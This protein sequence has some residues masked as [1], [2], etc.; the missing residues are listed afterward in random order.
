MLGEADT[1][2]FIPPTG[3]AV[4]TREGYLEV[5]V[6]KIRSN[7]FQPRRKMDPE[8]I[9]ELASSITA[10]GLIQPLV[11]NDSGEGNFEL[12]SGERRLRAVKKLGWDRV[13]AIVRQVGESELLEITLVENLQR[14]DLNSIE[15]AMGYKRLSEEFHLTQ[16]RIAE[17]IG[18]DRATIAN[19]MRLLRLP[20]VI[21][22]EVASG[23]L[24]AGHARQL[25]ALDDETEQMELARRVIDREISVRRLEEI[26]RERK[27]S[28]EVRQVPGSGE[29]EKDEPSAQI[30]ALE[31]RLSRHLGTQVRI[32]NGHKGKGKIEVN[33][34]SFEE[35]ERLMELLGVSLA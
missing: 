17:R 16:A 33:F 26:I 18:K 11:V 9:S 3:P 25:L 7:R 20:E 8:S 30:L 35:F 23:A 27:R 21:Q 22:Q 13:P 2:G 15:E 4:E 29:R 12:I 31:D 34:Y 14:E 10:Q 1:S 6:D 19:T 5:P 32:R 28:A 24:S